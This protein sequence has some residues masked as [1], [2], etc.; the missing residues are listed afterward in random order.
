L[1]TAGAL[2]D[3]RFLPADATVIL[4]PDCNVTVKLE[5]PTMIDSI[6]AVEPETVR[7]TLLI[8]IVVEV[9]NVTSSKAARTITGIKITLRQIANLFICFFIML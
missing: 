5:S 3:R 1:I 4:D 8:V 7:L 9:S 2:V 6:E